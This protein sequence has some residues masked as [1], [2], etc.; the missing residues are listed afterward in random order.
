MNPLWFVGIVL[1]IFWAEIL[2]KWAKKSKMLNFYILLF[3]PFII[4][5]ITFF[6]MNTI[7]MTNLNIFITILI[8]GWQIL[9]GITLYTIGGREEKVWF[10]VVLVLNPLW[11]LYRGI[12]VIK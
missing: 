6:K 9:W 8:L 11:I 2:Y 10:Y 3:I 12:K 5:M 1:F 7:Q 4:G